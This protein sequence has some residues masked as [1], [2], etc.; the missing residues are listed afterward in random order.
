[1]PAAPAPCPEALAVNA[2]P[3]LPPSALGNVT[4]DDATP[5]LSASRA[6]ERCK[7]CLKNVRR[8]ADVAGKR[9]VEY[10]DRG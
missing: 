5:S 9:K 4:N 3:L 2:H 7:G 8:D 10:Y 6:Y 1:M